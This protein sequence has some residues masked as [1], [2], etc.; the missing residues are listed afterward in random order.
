M[1]KL[2]TPYQ[3][4]VGYTP[5][6]ANFA[7]HQRATAAL[8]HKQYALIIQKQVNHK[9]STATRAALLTYLLHGAES[10]FRS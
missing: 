10:F 3:L 2:K 7:N 5:H 9:Q 4:I 1:Y 6:T 8:H